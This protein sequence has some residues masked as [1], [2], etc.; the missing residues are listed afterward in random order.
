MEA[1]PGYQVRDMTV[2]SYTCCATHEVSM[3]QVLS[4]KA[5]Q[6]HFIY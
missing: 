2:K 3:R 1:T 4:F 6:Y 5:F